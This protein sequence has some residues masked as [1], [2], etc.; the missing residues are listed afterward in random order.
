[1]QGVNFGSYEQ[2]RNVLSAIFPNELLQLSTDNVC[3][4]KAVTNDG[5]VHG[6]THGHDEKES[7]L[8]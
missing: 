4:C 2:L 8:P 5:N 1:M 6:R 7:T 3:I